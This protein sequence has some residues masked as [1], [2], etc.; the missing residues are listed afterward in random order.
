MQF[1]STLDVIARRD[2][3]APSTDE[4]A[5]ALPPAELREV[6]TIHLAA[7]LGTVPTETKNSPIR[8]GN[9]AVDLDASKDQSGIFYEDIGAGFAVRGATLAQLDG[10]RRLADFLELLQY[11]RDRSDTLLYLPTD[12]RNERIENLA[13]SVGASERFVRFVLANYPAIERS[14]GP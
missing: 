5:L 1:G 14:F 13:K 2:A 3:R 10:P 6:A 7:L 8:F 4:I 12:M 11:A 9:L